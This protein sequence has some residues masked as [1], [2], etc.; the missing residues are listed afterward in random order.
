ML[1]ALEGC[2]DE[3]ARQALREVLYGG[4]APSSDSST[5]GETQSQSPYDRLLETL[6][7]RAVEFTREA[8]L[9]VLTDAERLIL[10]TDEQDFPDEAAKLAAFRTLQARLGIKNDNA[11]RQI[12]WRAKN[13]KIRKYVQARLI[14]YLR[15]LGLQVPPNAG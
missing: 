9:C 15:G 5:A 4:G 2:D 8:L 10:Q 7:D 3:S 14:E 6:E 11:R 13:K 1:A 12:L